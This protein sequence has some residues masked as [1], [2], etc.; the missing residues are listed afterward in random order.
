MLVGVGILVMLL[1]RMDLQQLGVASRGVHVDLLIIGIGMKVVVMWIKSVRWAIAIRGA[2]GRPVSRA[3]SAS[4]IGFAGNVLLPA[5]LGELAR[6][7]VIDKH[8]RIGRPLALTTVG[9]IQLFDLLILV[10][11]FFV[12]SIWATSLFTAH[13]LAMS[14]LGVAILLTLG[15]LA[16]LQQRSRPLRA[17]LFPISGKLPGALSRL[18]ARYT[19]LFMKG[20]GVLSKGSVVGWVLLLT[21]AVWVLETV[22][23]YLMLQ[24]FHIVT[25]PLMAAVVTVLLNLSFAFP[26]TPGNVGI[27]QAVAVFLLGTFGVT[28]ES[29]L[30]FSV[31]SQGTTYLV[32]VS[33][34]MLCFYREKMSLNLLGRAARED[35]HGKSA[36]LIE[37]S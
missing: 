35:A 36:T 1:S 37:P 22:A 11:Y 31:G 24:A 20:L 21:I 30:A 26:I 34:G 16:I 28:Q 12:I 2:I 33:L 4:M 13:R 23:V 6:V 17:L 10:S 27:A 14:L 19:D 8:N 5:R 15:G 25:S 18:I 3:F 29:A 9:V 7:S 32:I